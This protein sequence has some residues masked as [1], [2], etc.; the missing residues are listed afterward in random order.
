MQDPL[1]FIHRMLLPF[2]SPATI[3]KILSSKTPQASA[4]VLK[5]L[6]PSRALA[7]MGQWDPG[8]KLKVVKSMDDYL[9]R[10]IKVIDLEELSFYL[11]NLEAGMVRRLSMKIPD[12]VYANLM[13]I[14]NDDDLKLIL[15]NSNPKKGAFIIGRLPAERQA[16][17]LRDLQTWVQ[18]ALIQDL[19]PDVRAE[20]IDG[21][22]LEQAIDLL[23]RWGADVQ[24]SVLRLVERSRRQEILKSMGHKQIAEIIEM[25]P[26]EE[27]MAT[28]SG[29]DD[30]YMTQIL[31]NFNPVKQ[32]E[33]FKMLPPDRQRFIVSNLRTDQAVVFMRYL[34]DTEIQNM[35]N[36]LDTDTAK[37]LIKH[38]NK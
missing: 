34:P 31:F 28:V 27:Q 17:I 37:L 11:L 29:L 36:E 35:L 10:L 19:P 16:V 13:L 4:Y 2:Y 5:T 7:V 18:A 22:N 21:L 26:M 12:A 1:G 23:T 38:L 14:W 8:Y 6:V 32:E 25:W 33:L 20:V 15:T 24:S 9:Y 30:Q 3:A